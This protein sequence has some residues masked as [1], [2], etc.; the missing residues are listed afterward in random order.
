MLKKISNL[1]ALSLL[2]VNRFQRF[3]PLTSAFRS[4]SHTG[5]GYLYGSLLVL[6]LVSQEIQN[7][8]WAKVVIL[9]FLIELPCFVL[10][11]LL[12]KRGRPFTRFSECLR[13][14][15]PKDE[16]SMPSGHAAGAFLVANLVANFYTDFAALAYVWAILIALSRVFLGVHYPTDI[17]AGAVLGLVCSLVSLS[18]LVL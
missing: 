5:D 8:I 4:I 10:L 18:I 11:K 6:A 14:V 17:M 13:A 7:I 1:D 2:W 16:F 3:K 9:A 12:V 15:D